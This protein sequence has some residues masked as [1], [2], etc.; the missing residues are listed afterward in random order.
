MSKTPKGECHA[1]GRWVTFWKHTAYLRRHKTQP[2]GT[3]CPNGL[4]TITGN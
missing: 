2:G 1:C 3:W 4:R